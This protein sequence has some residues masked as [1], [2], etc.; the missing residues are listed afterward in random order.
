MKRNNY[1]PHYERAQE[2][3]RTLQMEI[4]A[5]SGLS[6]T[7]QKATKIQVSEEEQL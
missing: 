5:Y 3:I 7:M 2:T 1:K 4:E 6:D